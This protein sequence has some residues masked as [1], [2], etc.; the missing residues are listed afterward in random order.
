M[1]N[2]AISASH[3]P[4]IIET[5]QMQSKSTLP[6]EGQMAGLISDVVQHHV[7]CVYGLKKK[8]PSK[9]IIGFAISFAVLACI[10]IAVVMYALNQSQINYDKPLHHPA[11]SAMKFT[12]IL[13]GRFFNDDADDAV[14]LVLLYF[15]W[16][17]SN[18]GLGSV[19]SIGLD[20]MSDKRNSSL[21]GSHLHPILRIVLGSLFAVVI[22]LP[23]G[24]ENFIGLCYQLVTGFPMQPDPSLGG[25]TAGSI[26]IG[27]ILA[28][29]M[30]FVLGYNTTLVISILD[31]VTNSAQTFFNL[32]RA[33]GKQPVSVTEV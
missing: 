28:T 24:Y 29:I 22:M 11:L 4:Q 3:E 23:F 20:E 33:D 5:A 21:S 19:A 30:P 14:W 10:S 13:Q 26:S 31:Q 18:G 6:A 12:Q 16:L 27:Q 1:S 9:L 32:H 8:E 2:N 7:S 17:V 25:G 15:L